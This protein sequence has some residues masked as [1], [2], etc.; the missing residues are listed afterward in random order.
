MM[1]QERKESGKL[2]KHEQEEGKNS[3]ILQDRVPVE[4][5]P[6]TGGGA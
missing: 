6:V 5:I 2:L 3:G 4:L 1:P